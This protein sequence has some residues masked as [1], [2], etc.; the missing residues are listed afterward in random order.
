[1]LTAAL[2]WAMGPGAPTLA[3][4]YL[5]STIAFQ[6]VSFLILLAFLNKKLFR[7]MLEYLD[8]RAEGIK[9]TLDEANSAKETAEADR[10]AARDELDEARR[11]S[12][13]IRAQAREIAGSEGERILNEA[14]AEEEAI[15]DKA[16]REIAQSV[17]RARE[18][19]RDQTGAL[20]IEVAE[21]LLRAD[22]T[23]EQKR[24]ATMVYANETEGF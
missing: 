7:P 8:K 17:E 13:A 2:P 23:D 4:V 24:K 18:S 3:L 5:N 1:M 15:I 20:A 6:I 16:Q 21:K 14:R 22:L 11:E 12:Y 10:G 19:L 9:N